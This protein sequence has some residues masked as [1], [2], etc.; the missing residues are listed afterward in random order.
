VAQTSE[1]R[2]TCSRSSSLL[3]RWSHGAA[4]PPDSL[5]PRQ[6]TKMPPVTEP[7]DDDEPASDSPKGRPWRGVAIVLAVLVVL[8]AALAGVE[9]RKAS[10][11]SAKESTRHDVETVAGGFA[12]AL[13][14]YDY[15]DLTGARDRVVDLA[16]DNFAQQYTAGFSSGLG[17][18]ITS[19]Q[20]TAKATVR[21]VYVSDV[22][23]DN[24]KAVVAADT[25]V[26]SSSSTQRHLG[27]YLD[28]A[29]VH[30]GGK[31]RVDTVT[32]LGS[33]DDQT[34][35]APGSTTTTTTTVPTTTT[36]AN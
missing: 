26:H 24:A 18:Q 8:T 12:E 23:G 22:N 4:G 28:L 5:S 1:W 16:T 25:E 7:G 21:A 33:L 30:Q 20:A 13:L 2:R 9:W 31:W 36:T 6:P 15:N 3:V 34:S 32:Y 19:L 29:L 11:S 17:N 35:P 27:Q 10:D 14:S